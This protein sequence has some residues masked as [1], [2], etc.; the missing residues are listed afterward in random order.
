[1]WWAIAFTVIF[2]LTLRFLLDF[3]PPPKATLSSD[4]IAAFYTERHDEI[5]VGAVICSWTSAFML[6]LFAVIT[7]QMAR[8]EVGKIWTVLC[9][10]GGAMMSLFLMLPP[11]F[12][13]VAA[14]TPSRAHDVTALMHEL[15]TL[16]LTSTD[17]YYIF[18]W[19]AIVVVCFLP[20][21]AENS[22]FTRRYGY[23]TAW[24]AFMFEAGAIVFLPRTGP[25]AWNG[26]L[27]FWSPLT[28]FGIWIGVTCYVL[29]KAIRKQQEAA[30][31]EVAIAA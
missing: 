18:A 28:I 24:A 7:I 17:Q 1:V 20:Q 6:P 3:M 21:A 12:W 29:L 4:Q 16:T 31:R 2:G 26:L 14:F 19:V 22:P 15:G 10:M 25:F 30:D 5:R 9:G 13:G 11:L 27:V 23:F 8:V